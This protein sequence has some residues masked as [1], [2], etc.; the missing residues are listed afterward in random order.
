[1][2][3]AAR[4]QPVTP[5]PDAKAPPS[6]RLGAAL[7]SGDATAVPKILR[8]CR[9]IVMAARAGKLPSADTLDARDANARIYAI[10]IDLFLLWE[11]QR[12]GGEGLSAFERAEVDVKAAELRTWDALLL[13]VL[14]AQRALDAATAAYLLGV[15]RRAK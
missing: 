14:E 4:T 15:P 9:D 11:K 6:L 12:A 1:M 8:E 13:P 7:A 2:E 3:M 5:R 10:S